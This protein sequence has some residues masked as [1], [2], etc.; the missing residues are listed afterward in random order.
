MVPG[1]DNLRLNLY[2]RTRLIGLDRK[3]FNVKA[4]RVK[5]R[6]AAVDLPAVEGP[7]S[8]AKVGQPVRAT[9]ADGVVDLTVSSKSP[10]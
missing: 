7:K 4:E 10:N 5:A 6:N 1:V 8:L 9:L 3:F 2:L